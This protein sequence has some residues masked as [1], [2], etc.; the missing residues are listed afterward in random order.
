MIK[1]FS[2]VLIFFF[3]FIGKIN[4][5]ITDSA[6][7]KFIKVAERESDIFFVDHNPKNLFTEEGLVFYRTLASFE[8]PRKMLNYSGDAYSAISISLG[9]CKENRA[10]VLYVE[11]YDIKMEN[12]WIS[13]Y[14]ILNKRT[15]D[16]P[17]WKFFEKNS[18]GWKILR[19]ACDNVITAY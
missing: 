18:L 12:G 13:D 10:A 17:Q 8:K 3:A 7:S 14:K 5:Q 1:F 6:S 15:F 11:W 4:S 19:N 2:I 9:N 16:E